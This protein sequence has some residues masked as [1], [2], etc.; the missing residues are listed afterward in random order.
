MAEKKRLSRDCDTCGDAMILEY[1]PEPETR[2][3]RCRKVSGTTCETCEK[4]LATNPL[5]PWI[6]KVAGKAACD[7]KKAH[8]EDK[9]HYTI[10]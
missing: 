1:K 7:A 9:N 8:E 5:G 2:R 10:N 4:I 6:V 3:G